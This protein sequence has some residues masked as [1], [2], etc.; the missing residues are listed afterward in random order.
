M[1]VTN[2]EIE[3]FVDRLMDEAPGDDYTQRLGRK[4]WHLI[5][6]MADT[7]GCGTCRP[8]AQMLFSGVHDAVNIHLG[9]EV[10]DKKN[11]RAFVEAIKHADKHVK[12]EIE[13]KEIEL[14]H[15]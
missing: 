4:V 14:E 12:S 15:G 8:A 13:H 2:E 6:T 7:Y 10:Y 1:T 11:W 5:H 9:K 3:S